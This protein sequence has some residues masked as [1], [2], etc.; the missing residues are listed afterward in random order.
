EIEYVKVYLHNHGQDVES[1]WCE[2]L[3]AVGE[4]ALLRLMNVPFLHAKPTFGDVI[5]AERNTTYDN[6]YAWDRRDIPWDRIGERIHHDG[7][8]Y[9]LIV[10]YTPTPASA[11]FA[12]LCKLLRAEHGIVAERCFGPKDGRPGRLY[13]AARE[14]MEP[15]E[16]MDLLRQSGTT[17]R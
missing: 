7:G 12:E 4:S 5:A 8:R 10:E 2:P 13:L 16:V 14:T 17:F 3:V 15:T 1:A 11:D 9:A 6:H